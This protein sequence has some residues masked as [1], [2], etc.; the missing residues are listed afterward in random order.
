MRLTVLFSLTPFLHEVLSEVLPRQSSN[1]SLNPNIAYIDAE[2]TYLIPQPFRSNLTEDFV[3]SEASNSTVQA[4]FNE[5]QAAPFVS[6]SEEFNDLLGPNARLLD[7]IPI[8]T[9]APL[10]FAGEGGAWVPELNQVWLTSTL[11][12]GDTSIWVFHL[13]DYSVSQPNFTAAP[14]YGNVLPLPNPGGLYYFNG[15]VYAMLNGNERDSSSM[16]AINVYTLEVT[17][18]VNSYF[19]LEYP[20]FD[21][22]AISYFETHEGLQTHIVS[23]N[24]SR[25]IFCGRFGS[26]SNCILSTSRLLH[27]HLL[28]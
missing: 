11:Y 9:T 3:Q 16:A 21:D 25:I 7:A 12:A 17:P 1:Q 14:G 6:F 20:V 5:A 27:L 26:S 24:T 23:G 13:D 8:N 19:G 4:V 28:V 22:L 2:L 18:V 10:G 15:S